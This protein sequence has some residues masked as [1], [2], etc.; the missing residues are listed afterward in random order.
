LVTDD[1]CG[2]V[3][4]ETGRMPRAMPLIVE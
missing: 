4:I 3:R 2:V 1:V